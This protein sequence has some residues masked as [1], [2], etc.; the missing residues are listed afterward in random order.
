M[1][2]YKHP[3]DA[4]IFGQYSFKDERCSYETVYY[5]VQ[6]GKYDF[7]SEWTFFFCFIEFFQSH[8]F[9]FLFKDPYVSDESSFNVTNKISFVKNGAG[10]EIEYSLSPRGVGIFQNLGPQAERQILPTASFKRTPALQIRSINPNF[11]N[12]GK[13]NLKV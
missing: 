7:T 6:N 2:I 5:Y 13:Q 3:D 12:I 8:Q 1:V 4:R 10:Y 9:Q 11:A